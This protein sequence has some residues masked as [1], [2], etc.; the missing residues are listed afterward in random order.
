MLTVKIMSPNGG[1]E[2]HSCMSIGY[3][4]KQKSITVSGLDNDLFL[5]PGE[6]AYVMNDA[7]KTISSYANP[8]DLA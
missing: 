5:Q 8:S 3:N 7:G 4:A 2:I 6:M 1:E